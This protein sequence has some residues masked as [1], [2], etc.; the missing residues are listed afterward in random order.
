MKVSPYL[1]VVLFTIT[2]MQSQG[3]VKK[4]IYRTRIEFLNG[5]IAKGYLF[6]LNDSNI[7]ISTSFK[8]FSDTIFAIHQIKKISLRKK[9]AK[10]NGFL[11][12]MASGAV[13]GAVIGYASYSPP[14]P[15]VGGFCI[16]L[17]DG[18]DYSALGGAILG[19]LTGGML[20]L[21]AGARYKKYVINGD[22]A[23]YNNLRN[24]TVLFV[25][26]KK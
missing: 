12:G 19:S 1:L 2:L 24:N 23:K 13:V 5:E 18:P 7:Q 4:T 14:P 8:P 21:A 22:I 25:N 10:G 3:Q 16:N 11:I 26:V 20:G 15:C 17:F 6:A 9:N